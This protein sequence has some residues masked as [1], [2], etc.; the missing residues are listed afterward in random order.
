M[1]TNNSISHENKHE[2]KTPEE[3]LRATATEFNAFHKKARDALEGN[4]DSATYK[5]KLRES[6]SLLI[7]LPLK[8]E[9]AIERGETF[10]DTAMD[11]V[12]FFAE[13]AT[14]MVETN[15]IFGLAALLTHKGSKF[16]DP[17]DLEKLINKL[18]PPKQP[19]L[20][21]QK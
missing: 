15:N 9:G 1:E 10:P 17:N 2:P 12:R 20:R 13:H 7:N 6:A 8:L 21:S 4:R 14:E 18:Y 19:P 11:D 3:I 5:L 16:G